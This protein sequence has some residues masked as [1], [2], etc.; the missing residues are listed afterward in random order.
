MEVEERETW[1]RVDHILYG[2]IEFGNDERL[3]KLDSLKKW[4]RP[5]PDRAINGLCSQSSI[6]SLS[7]FGQRDSLIFNI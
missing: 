4:D 7:C 1:I 5:T 2:E 6:T 3:R